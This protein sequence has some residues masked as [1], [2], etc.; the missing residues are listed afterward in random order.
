MA[1]I[2]SIP[3]IEVAIIVESNDLQEYA[4]PDIEE[5][6]NTITRYIEARHKA[7]F[8][9]RYH[10]GQGFKMKGNCISLS[11]KIDGQ[12]VSHPVIKEK[13]VQHAAC[14]GMVKGIRVSKSELKCF[15]FSIIETGL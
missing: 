13:K 10:I 7:E 2:E 14:N 11:V 15:S 6:P 3:G 8:Q 4:D 12:R 5:E 1:I 9:I